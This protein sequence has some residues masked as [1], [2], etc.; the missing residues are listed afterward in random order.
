MLAANPRDSPPVKT[1][2]CI[3][4]GCQVLLDRVLH[5]REVCY[6]VAKTHLITAIKSTSPLSTSTEPI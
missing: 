2:V 1:K 6:S 4:Y 5:T 3:L